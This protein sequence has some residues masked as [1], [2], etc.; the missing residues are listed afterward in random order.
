MTNVDVSPPHVRASP[1]VSDRDIV[2]DSAQNI[3]INWRDL[4]VDG[5]FAIGDIANSLVLRSAERGFPVTDKRVYKAVGRFCGKSGRTVRYYAETSAF[6]PE[7]VRDEFDVLPFSHFV[8]ARSMGGRWREILEYASTV[9]E[10]TQVALRVKFVYGI[11]ID[12]TC[13]H[14]Q[15]IGDNGHGGYDGEVSKIGEVSQISSGAGTHL[16]L[17]LLSR[18]SADMGELRNVVWEL[19]MDSDRKSEFLD[20]I[21]AVERLVPEL[22]KVV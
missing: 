10:V 16:A 20:A 1:R 18:V 19:D 15:V 13:E 6:Y 17:S 8:F 14:S 11:D 22:S 7:E 2:P 5:Y 4:F 12:K 9:P 3:L 21:K